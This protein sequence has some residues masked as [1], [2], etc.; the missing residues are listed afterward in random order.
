M[1][2]TGL[3][4]EEAQARALECLSLL[5]FVLGKLGKA[6]ARKWK[7]LGE[8]YL[9]HATIS[10]SSKSKQVYDCNPNKLDHFQW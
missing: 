10:A 4:V 9:R 6:Q 5:N 8:V 2:V 1:R 7:K 3:E